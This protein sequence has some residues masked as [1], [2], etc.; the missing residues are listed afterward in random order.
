MTDPATLFPRQHVPALSLELA[1]GGRFDLAAEAPAHFTLVLFYRGLHCP[2]CK[3]QLIE[4]QSRLDAFEAKG[5]SVVAIS[6]DDQE[7][8]EKTCADW[9]LERLRVGFGLKLEEA[10]AWGLFVSAGRDGEPARFT[11]P[12]LFLLRPD[13]TL[14]FSS[15]QTMPFARP[16]VADILGA[17]DYVLQNDYPAR[18]E[19]EHL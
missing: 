9:K 12:G 18:G 14:Y 13:G 16:H 5:V 8:A 6:A 3:A 1:G 11:E 4:L 10:R 15:V 17:I 7:R 2:I 19:V